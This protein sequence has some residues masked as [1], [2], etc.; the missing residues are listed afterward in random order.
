VTAA[1]DADAEGRYA[2]AV[3]RRDAI[4]TAWEAEGSPCSR[5]APPASYRAPVREDAAAPRRARRSPSGRRAQAA[6]WSR[7]FRGTHAFD[8][9]VAGGKASSGELV[10][11]PGAGNGN[12][13][14]FPEPWPPLV[15]GLPRP[16]SAGV[17]ACR[18]ELDKRGRT[19]EGESCG[20][21]PLV[22]PVGAIPRPTSWYGV[23]QT[24]LPPRPS[25]EGL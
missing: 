5:P 15:T 22:A 12:R 10:V 1:L 6:P 7:V 4:R 11:R 13:R 21:C 8:R 2:D 14:P 23:R 3:A 17:C 25:A 9:R 24:P 18:P 19:W 16:A 20:L